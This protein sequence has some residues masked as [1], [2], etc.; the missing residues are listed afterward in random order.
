M[1]TTLAPR[2]QSALEAGKPV[3]H[4]AVVWLSVLNAAVDSQDDFKASVSQYNMDF[5]FNRNFARLAVEQGIYD[6]NQASQNASQAAFAS[7]SKYMVQRIRISPARA[8]TKAAIYVGNSSGSPLPVTLALY[9]V[10]PQPADSGVSYNIPSSWQGLVFTKTQDCPASTTGELVYTFDPVALPEG[11]YYLVVHGNDAP[12]S[13]AL[14][15]YYQNSD[16]YADGSLSICAKNVQTIALAGIWTSY[17]SYDLY[18]RLELSGFEPSGGFTTKVMDLGEVPLAPGVFQVLAA[19]VPAGT[20][21]D[22]SLSGSAGA[23]MSSPYVIAKAEDAAELPAGYRY[24]QATVTCYSNADLSKSPLI[25]LIEV[26]FPKDRLRMREYGRPLRQVED[27]LLR[28]Y[29]PL[30]ESMSFDASSIN[31]MDRVSSLGGASCKLKDPQGEA[32]KRIVSSYP[33]KN[34]RCQLYAGCDVPG[35]RESDLL[36]TFTGI[37]SAAAPKPKYRKESVGLELTFH[38]PLFELTRK[39]PQPIQ[40]GLIDAAEL[41]VSHDGLHVMDSMMDLIRGHAGI[42]ARYVN[43]PSFYGAKGTIGDGTPAPQAYIVYRS[44]VSGLPDTRIKSPEELRKLLAALCV[45]ADGYIVIDEHTR[46]AFVKHDP[47]ATPAAIWADEDLVKDG[48]VAV[49]IED[50]ADL[51]LGYKDRIYNAAIMGCAWNGTGDKWDAFT[52]YANIDADAV[53]EWSPGLSTY[54]RIMEKNLIEPSKWLGLEANYNGESIAQSLAA[55]F[56]ARNAYPPVL[57]KGVKVPVTQ[58]VRA[59]GDV[60]QLWSK[61]FVRFK[62]NGIALSETLRFMITSKQYNRGENRMLFDLMEL[63]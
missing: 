30:M 36:R 5:D 59:C 56:T 35:F 23:D 57:L 52:A 48:A 4:F 3:E 41:S 13:A 60:V 63:T 61:E 1:I 2:T 26:M 14:S 49:P 51:D 20:R 9:N 8:I 29:A 19:E 27:S 37:V 6:I 53:D 16:V 25:D 31:I 62:R 58:Y 46:L 47:S 18:F 45:I 22:V 32:I 38:N 33:L 7:S 17:P 21:M 44:N 50:V 28:D 54:L 15:F 39:I 43:A 11:Y 12:A 42:P 34:Y 55:R 24:W 40:T 10:N